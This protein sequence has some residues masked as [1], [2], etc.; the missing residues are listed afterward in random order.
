ML[1]VIA[2][3]RVV[4]TGHSDRLGHKRSD[5]WFDKCARD[6]EAVLASTRFKLVIGSIGI[7]I[8]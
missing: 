8:K 4:S 2:A 6:V 1:A 5:S 3:R 7:D